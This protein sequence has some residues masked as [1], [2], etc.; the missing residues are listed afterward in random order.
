MLINITQDICVSK[1]SNAHNDQWICY[2][3]ASGSELRKRPVWQRTSGLMST[4]AMHSWLRTQYPETNMAS[5]F[6]KIANV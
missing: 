2:S 6:G 3:P 1:H 5:V 4:S